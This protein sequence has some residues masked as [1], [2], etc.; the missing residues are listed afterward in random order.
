MNRGEVV[1]NIPGSIPK[2]EIY[3]RIGQLQSKLKEREI[4]AAIIAQNVDLFYFTGCCQSGH[5]I[6][7]A[8]AG[9]E[10]LYLV[11]KSYSRALIESP[12]KNIRL[13][14]K[15]REIPSMLGE[16][17]P[18]VNRIGMELDVLPA[19]FYFRYRELFPGMEI[20]DL[21]AA[22]KEIRMLKS[23]FELGIIKKAAKISDSMFEAAP[24]F[25][26]EGK[27]EVEF[28][29]EVERFLRSNGHQG[30]THVRQFNQECHYG[31]IMSGGENTTYASFFDSPTGGPGLSPAYPQSAGWKKIN[32]NDPVL[33]DY[34]TVYYGYHV[35]C[36][37]V[38]CLGEPAGTLEKAHRAALNIQNEVVKMGK[39][40]VLCSELYEFALKMAEDLGY[41]E[42]FMG[43][44]TDKAAFIGHGVGL[45]LDELPVL[46]SSHQYPLEEG[47]VFALEP[48]ILLPGIGV[49]GVE[50]TVLVT[51]QGLEKLNLHPEEI[52]VC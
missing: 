30:G 44:G 23:P 27:M 51:A 20:V 7:A 17:A 4:D 18:G 29:A 46:T 48:K 35:D 50:N 2:E 9:S 16:I 36:T 47:M 41:R 26:K 24:R 33:L 28:A 34:L 19:A 43:L 8:A 5:L 21:S 6:V 40:G 10:P 37:R 25:L 12:L 14:E 3:Q 1:Q 49:A 39:P 52:I 45:E 38:F 15:F 11:K 13:Q 31:H 42:Y 32:K 22:I